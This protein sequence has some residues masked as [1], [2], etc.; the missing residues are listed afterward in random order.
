MFSILASLGLY[1]ALLAHPENTE[2]LK[3]DGS[4]LKRVGVYCKDAVLWRARAAEQRE[5]IK[6]QGVLG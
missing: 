6:C 4:A 5:M 3:I 2:E 1:L